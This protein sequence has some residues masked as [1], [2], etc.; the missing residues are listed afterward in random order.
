MSRHHAF[1]LIWLAALV[2]VGSAEESKATLS[3][4]AASV[5]FG[6]KF[7]AGFWQ[8]V[9]L[10]VQAGPAG[11]KGRLELISPDGD[12][13]PVIYANEQVPELNLAADHEASL[14]LYARIGPVGAPLTAQLRSG[15]KV[16]WSHDLTPLVPRAL[17]P[18]QEL[19]VGLGPPPGIDE[20]LATI[21][22][23]PEVSLVT[24]K[25][26]AAA[27]LPDQWW[28]YEGVDTVVL[29]TSDAKFFSDFSTAQQQALIEWVQ[30]GGRLVLLVGDRGAQVAAADSPWS[31]LLPGKFAEVVPLSE[32]SGLET[33]TKTD[34][35]FEDELFQRERPRLTRLTN[36]R[37]EVLVGEESSGAHPLV[38]HAPAS[39]GEIWFIGLDLDHRALAKWPGR[40]RLLSEVLQRDRLRREASSQ[41]SHPKFTQLGFTD[42]IGQLRTALDQFPGVTM[43]NITT[44]SV[45]TGI[46]LLLIGPGDYFLL[47]WLGW[48][49]QITWFT[50]PLVAAGFI[51]AAVLL[52]GQAHGHRLRLNQAEI[53]DID[54]A[55]SRA[56]GTVWSQLYSPATLHFNPQT[57]LSPPPEMIEKSQGWL[58]WQGLPGDALGGLSSQQI[59]LATT[60]PY[61]ASM[62]GASFRLTGVPVTIGSSKSLL[63]RWWAK[64]TL[65]AETQLTL[66]QY[67]L[68]A[69]DFQNPLPIE[70]SECVLAHSDKLYR[71]GTLRPGQTAHIDPQ[72]SLNL[73]WRLTL[74]TI[75]DTKDVA[76]PWDQASVEVPRI[77]QMLMFHEA[78]R[79]RGYTGL[80]HRY[81]P[82]VDLSEHIRLGQA[83]LVG[84][85]A[86]PVAQLQ[87]AGTPLA[88][89]ENTTTWTWYRVL[90]PINPRS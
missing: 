49:R 88:N 54:L 76:T 17:L 50:F 41:E 34:L 2:A 90:L 66:N 85:G 28:A 4:K 3:V 15:D 38:I 8:P 13:A 74:R 1:A 56:R 64:S 9:R 71:L 22:R 43:V 40:V 80:T 7:K 75:V 6:G 84:R 65:P 86:A 45:L 48:P 89:P 25:V 36:V 59:A 31:A 27:E 82:F 47:S 67:G 35:P 20:A 14:L 77:V 33:F 16:L 12:Q 24:A 29:T 39:F 26:G 11:A 57:K 10:T 70:L 46:Y 81:Q 19:I 55:G 18:T 72:L 78:A 51:A 53:V 61:R 21:R 60:E 30:L 62:P 58:T 5:G 83:V 73:E 69:G 87:Q 42:L 44:V 37:G 23:Q 32:R 79:G 63:T 52:A 68:L